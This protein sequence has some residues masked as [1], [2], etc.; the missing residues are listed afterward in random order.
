MSSTVSLGLVSSRRSRARSPSFRTVRFSIPHDDVAADGDWFAGDDS[1]P[2]TPAD[3]IGRGRL[4]DRE[5][6]QEAVRPVQV[7]RLGDRRRHLGGLHATERVVVVPLLDEGRHH[8]LDDGRRDGEADVLAAAGAVDAEHLPVVAGD[9]RPAEASLRRERLER[10]VDVLE[11]S[12]PREGDGDGVD[13][14]E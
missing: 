12:R 7:V 13:A 5:Q 14:I 3:G 10:R 11:F 8:A 2:V 4:R 9:E 6:D 1:D